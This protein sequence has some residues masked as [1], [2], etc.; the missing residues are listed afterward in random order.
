MKLTAEEIRN[1]TDWLE[2]VGCPAFIISEAV[3]S[4]KDLVRFAYKSTGLSAR[5]ITKNPF[6]STI[7]Y[8][9]S[10]SINIKKLNIPFLKNWRLS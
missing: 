5:T 8:M 6:P 3:K 2:N 4:R 1:A 7:Y 9:R 10:K